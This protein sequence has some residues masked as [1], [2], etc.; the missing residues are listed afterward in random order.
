MNELDQR[1]RQFTSEI[2]EIVPYNPCWTSMFEDEANSLLKLF[3]DGLIERIEHFGSTAV[4][5]LAAKPIVDML[6]QVRSLREAVERIVPVLTSMNYDYF[7]RPP[8]GDDAPTEEWY[9]WFVKRDPQAKR[10]H[11]LHVVEASSRLWERLFFRDY[12]RDHPE[13]AIRYSNL[14]IELASAHPNDRTVYTQGKNDFIAAVMKQ[15]AR[16]E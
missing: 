2:I 6:I 11:H 8:F 5:G 3:P 12:L 10:T 9:A 15:I 13:I 14:K 4:P 7:W 1:I 16:Q